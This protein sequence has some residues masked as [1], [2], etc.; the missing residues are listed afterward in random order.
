[1]PS[2]LLTLPVATLKPYQPQPPP[3]TPLRH[4]CSA[5]GTY[6][7]AAAANNGNGRPYNECKA[8]GTGTW[9]GGE[10]SPTNNVCEKIPAGEWRQLGRAGPGA[11]TTGEHIAWDSATACRQPG[12]AHNALPSFQLLGWLAA[13]STGAGYYA[14][15]GKDTLT[16]CPKGQVSFWDDSQSARTPSDDTTCRACTA[17]TYAPRLGAPARALC[18]ACLAQQAWQRAPP[19][20][21]GAWPCSDVSVIAHTHF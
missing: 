4:L 17:N 1:M 10:A 11:K 6:A 15:A 9:R 13:G 3:C 2:A 20:H 5:A 21:T 8:C 12:A 7:G 18:T 16:L 14:N 19:L